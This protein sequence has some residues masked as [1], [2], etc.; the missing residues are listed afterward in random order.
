MVVDDESNMFPILFL[1]L[2]QARKTNMTYS[3]DS[4][5]YDCMLNFYLVEQMFCAL[6]TIPYHG[7]Q[8]SAESIRFHFEKLVYLS[9]PSAIYRFKNSTHCAQTQTSCHIEHSRMQNNH[10]VY[11]N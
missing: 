4:R 11:H 6:F 8:R 5:I 10:H 3:S 2:S 9:T 1:I 7:S